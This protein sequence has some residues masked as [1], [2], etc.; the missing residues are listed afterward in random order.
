MKSRNRLR[1]D[2]FDPIYSG[3]LHVSAIGKRTK[4]WNPPKE[5]KEK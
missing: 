1:V 4:R 3:G 5:E 2:G